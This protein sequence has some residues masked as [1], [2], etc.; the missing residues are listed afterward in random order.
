MGADSQIEFSQV[1]AIVERVHAE[2]SRG[3]AHLSVAEVMRIFSDAD[4]D[5]SGML[6]AEEAASAARRLGLG[7]EGGQLPETQ[8]QNRQRAR[9]QRRVRVRAAFMPLSSEMVA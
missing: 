1:L 6:D 8:R 4:R 2:H 3:G 5:N 9:P 7:T